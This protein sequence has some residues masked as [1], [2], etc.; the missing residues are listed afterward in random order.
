MGPAQCGQLWRSSPKTWRSSHAQG[1]LRGSWSMLSVT[2]SPAAKSSS[3][4]T[5]PG[6]LRGAGCGTTSWRALAWEVITLCRR[7][8]VRHRPLSVAPA[9]RLQRA[10]ASPSAELERRSALLRARRWQ[11]QKCVARVDDG[12]R[13][14]CRDVRRLASRRA[15]RARRAERPAR[16]L[17]STWR[18]PWRIHGHE[19]CSRCDNRQRPP[20]YS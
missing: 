17:P 7:T 14:V 5:R 8:G 2:S 20:T 13:K 9:T 16:R 4:T 10:R 6:A 12:R 19:G 15:S 18:P 11:Q 1:F 3:C